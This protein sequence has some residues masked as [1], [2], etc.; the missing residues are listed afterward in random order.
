MYDPGPFLFS[1][2]CVSRMENTQIGL[3]RSRR[4]R[5]N[6]PER[7]TP[8]ANLSRNQSHEAGR[9]GIILT[10]AST[11][12][13]YKPY[14]EIEMQVIKGRRNRICSSCTEE[15]SLISGR[16]RVKETIRQNRRI[17]RRCSSGPVSSGDVV[18]KRSDMCHVAMERIEKSVLASTH[19]LT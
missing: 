15:T 3:H 4:G 14:T 6:A 7:P 8:S 10:N 13:C 12:I 11:W 18:T 9:R 5:E 1:C 17:C 19:K 16:L 2:G